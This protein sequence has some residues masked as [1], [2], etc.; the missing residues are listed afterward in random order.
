MQQEVLPLFPL[1]VVLFP[2]TQLPL[3]IFEERYKELIAQVID[4]QSEFGIVLAADDGVV[5][6]GCTA[7]VDTVTHRYPDGKLDIVT[8][9]VRRFEIESLDTEKT[10]LQGAVSYFNDEET[11]SAPAE[12]REKAVAGFQKMCRFLQGGSPPEPAWD[13]PQL[14]F[15]LAQAIQDLEFRQQLL[16]L[17]SES[18]RIRRLAEFF[19][20]HVTRQV[21]I[22]HVQKVAPGNGHGRNDPDD[23]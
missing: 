23:G 11:G 16:T 22:R 4:D 8:V 20:R 10:Y 3:H 14:S 21:H 15:Q 1:S 5:S 12:E 2:R 6:T 7:V 19:P 13:D 9:G 18:E 17:R